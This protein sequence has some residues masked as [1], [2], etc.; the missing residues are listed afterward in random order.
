MKKLYNNFLLPFFILFIIFSPKLKAERV[1]VDRG[2][3]A[4]VSTGHPLATKAAVKILK[5]GGNAI[6]AAVA[7]AFM[8][9]VVDFTNSG[10][11]GD[12]FALVHL[13][14]GTIISFDASSKKPENFGQNK[15]NIGLPTQVKL[16]FRLLKTFGSLNATKVL[17]PAI[18][19]CNE[20]FKVTGYLNNVIKKKLL[21]IKNKAAMDFLAPDGYA[22]PA[23]TIFKQP[24]LGRTLQKLAQDYGYSFYHGKMAEKMVE[25]MQNLG[26]SISLND[27]SKYNCRISKPVKLNWQNFSLYGTP[28]PSC[29]IVAMKLAVDLLDSKLELFPR[30]PA[31]LLK[32]AI[33]GRKLIEFKY[34]QL[35]S[36]VQQPYEFCKNFDQVKHKIEPSSPADANTQTTHLCVWDNNGL[37]VSM[38]LT[39]GSHCGTGELSPSGF[40]Y[41]NETRNYTKLVA[42]YPHN[43][44][45]KFGPISAKAPL[46]IKKDGKLHS[47]MGG[48]GSNRIIFNIGLT[49]AR[50][51]KRPESLNRVLKLPRFFL[52]YRQCLQLEWSK[53]I[54]FTRNCL[55]SWKNSKIRESGSDYFGLVTL[56]SKINDIYNS[57]AD[58][59]RD[60]DCRSIS[61]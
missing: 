51:I 20:G 49:A 7:A 16:L 3:L 23:G 5:Q 31:D 17:T 54:S 43:Y 13:E 34:R 58:F 59:R 12:G 33:K 24:V 45:Q 19:Q 22:L 46:M 57:A 48:A 53:N 35:A 10:L 60:G 11:G 26:S 30:T 15:S 8:L 9:G 50:I 47:I 4:A 52:D 1:F 36:F 14:N 6:D 61:K 27:L 44:P 38:T 29:S 40:F 56:L 25:D 55:N 2:D 42:K 28:P 32:I 37:A 39:L 18:K 41:N 21:R